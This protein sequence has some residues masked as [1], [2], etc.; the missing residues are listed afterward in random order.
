MV[1]IF[2]L[3]FVEL[4]FFKKKKKIDAWYYFTAIKNSLR[5]LAFLKFWSFHLR[6]TGKTYK[7]LHFL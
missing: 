2:Y 4:F 5:F 3:Q 7:H 1:F 6:F